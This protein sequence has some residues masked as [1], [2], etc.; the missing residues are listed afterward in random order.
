LDNHG[1]SHGWHAATCVAAAG[2][3]SIVQ[4]HKPG[5]FLQ[6]KQFHQ[7]QPD[8]LFGHFSYDLKNE[9]FGLSDSRE[10]IFDFPLVYFF[11]PSYIFLLNENNVQVGLWG[12]EQEARKI[13]SD[14]L[15]I[16]TFYIPQLHSIQISS[17]M[18]S[19]E[20]IRTVQHIQQH[21]HRGDCYELNYC[22]EF[23]AEATAILPA[24]IYEKLSPAP[25]S[26]FY[27]L[28]D[29]YLLC[30]SPERFL[31]KTGY[32]VISQPM[33]GTVRRSEDKDEDEKLK[34]YLQQ[35]SKERSENLIVTD[36]MRNDLSRTAVPGTVLVKELLTVYSYP[37][38]HQ[39]VSTIVSEMDPVYHFTDVIAQA[40]PMGS[41]TGAP[42]KRVLQLI[43]QYE[44]S[45]R[46]LFSGAMGYIMPEGDFDFNVIIRSILYDASA[47]YLSF[48]AGSGITFYSDP[49]KEWEECLLKAAGMGKALT[50]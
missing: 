39:L 35:N 1:W 3:K 33:K 17:R 31:Q 44:K 7:Q 15:D 27:R 13:L 18:Q 49:R 12:N 24:D 47:R 38:V 8:W 10:D 6:L 23:F 32:R 43:D 41:M 21:I 16:K 29:Q 46:G 50:A 4:T 42:K 20:Y 34:E 5:G 2:G 28:H 40:F 19:D 48:S 30:S 11:C 26:A 14:I 36:L 25:F 9:L 45:R 22:Q 37:A